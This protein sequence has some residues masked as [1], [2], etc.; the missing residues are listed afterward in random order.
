MNSQCVTHT[1]TRQSC[2]L[3]RARL[4]QTYTCLW[5]EGHRHMQGYI[6]M[7]TYIQLE[8]MELNR[9]WLYTVYNVQNPT[10]CIIRVCMYVCWVQDIAQC[11]CSQIK[12]CLS[13][14]VPVQPHV[15]VSTYLHTHQTLCKKPPQLFYS[16]FNKMIIHPYILVQ[17]KWFN[18]VRTCWC[19]CYLHQYGS[20][21][22]ACDLDFVISC[23]LFPTIVMVAS[24]FFSII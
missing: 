5:L 15:H 17:F 11:M 7:C 4:P 21:L 24:M 1:G 9:I 14:P 22:K 3:R 10:F 8:G 18:M 6:G 23:I 19:T 2:L 13:I 12:H 20:L 16:I